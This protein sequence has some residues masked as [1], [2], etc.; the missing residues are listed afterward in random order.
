[1][2]ASLAVGTGLDYIHFAACLTGLVLLMAALTA[3]GLFVSTLFRYP[4]LAAT[5][6]FAVLVFLW[7]AHVAINTDIGVANLLLNYLS[8]YPHFVSF[9]QGVFSTTD[10][11][12]FVIVSI[13]FVSL[14]IWRL[15]VIQNQHW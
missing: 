7:T 6:T 9:T 2:P 12:Y 3:I 15:D 13:T 10:F 4:V 11:F 5:V 1:V 14:S 8:M